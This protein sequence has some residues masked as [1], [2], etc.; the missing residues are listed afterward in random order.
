MF[1]SLDTLVLS[2]LID[3]NDNLKEGKCCKNIEFL[4]FESGRKNQK[5]KISA[6]SANIAII[7]ILKANF[8][9][10]I[11]IPDVSKWRLCSDKASH[12][13]K[14]QLQIEYNIIRSNSGK[15]NASILSNLLKIKLAKFLKNAKNSSKSKTGAFT[16]ED[17]NN[18]RGYCKSNFMQSPINIIKSETLVNQ[19][20]D[21]N[22]SYNFLDTF[23]KIEKRYGESIIKFT[24]NPGLITIILGNKN[25]V[26]MPKYISFRF[27]GEHINQGKKYNGEMLIHC[28]EINPDKV[29]I[30][31][32]LENS[33][34]KRINHNYSFR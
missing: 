28:N 12:I 18:W 2:K 21:F 3:K 22:L 31:I 27:P 1:K 6:K 5:S 30:L 16:W 7:N 20:K 34:F 10:D 4:N 11:F 19:Q 17:Q 9:L 29:F 8:C 14:L 23:V 33:N 13:S 26:F 25:V 15:N 24:N 32:N